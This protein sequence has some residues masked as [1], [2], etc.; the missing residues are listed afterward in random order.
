M[1][2]TLLGV[3]AFVLLLSTL[4]T[5]VIITSSA[6]AAEIN[7]HI[8]DVYAVS[9]DQ[10]IIVDGL[11]DK[12][13]LESPALL[14][15]MRI[16]DIKGLYTQGVFRFAWSPSENAIYCHVI[17][18]DVDVSA[19]GA[20]PWESDSVELFLHRGNDNR[21]DFQLSNWQTLSRGRQYRIDGYSNEP[22]CLLHEE[23][24]TYT[25]DES[26]GRL[27]GGT[28]G[29]QLMITDTDNHFGWYKGGW[30]ASVFDDGGT[31]GYAVEFKITYPENEPLTAGEDF[32]FDVQ[33]NDRYNNGNEQQIFY[34]SGARMVEGVQRGKE[35]AKYDYFTLSSTNVANDGHIANDQLGSYGR[36]DASTM[37]TGDLISKPWVSTVRSSY[38]RSV[39]TG[40]ISNVVN[41]NTSATT[42]EVANNGGGCGGTIAAGSSVI[43]LAMAGATGFF[44][45][46]RRRNGEDE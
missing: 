8:G 35:L 17:I 45:F 42:T 18:N 25:W 2:K 43:V 34:H 29:S 3:L 44:A 41:T 20:Q 37:T 10:P 19:P 13:Y 33:V 36:S 26:L 30:G 21:T 16:N 5:G 24:T 31:K 23:F 39:R 15:D 7:A 40:T 4:L 1:K 12:G 46:R 14:I 38:I 27:S 32:R 22:S 11:L 6:A 28:A 9:E